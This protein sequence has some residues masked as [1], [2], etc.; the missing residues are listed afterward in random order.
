MNRS[1]NYIGLGYPMQFNTPY[2]KLFD[3]INTAKIS[4]Y[5]LRDIRLCCEILTDAYPSNLGIVPY[6]W[7]FS[8][9]NAIG[10]IYFGP[11]TNRIPT[12]FY[13]FKI[14]ST[15]IFFLLLEKKKKPLKS[16]SNFKFKF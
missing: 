16:I 3:F 10:L 14:D 5:Y 8:L 15:A 4:V 2:Y 9:Q 13:I 12:F 11:H 7:K 6:F 1:S